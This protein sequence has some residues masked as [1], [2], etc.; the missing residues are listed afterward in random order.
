MKRAFGTEEYRN[1]YE[2]CK[3]KRPLE[4]SRNRWARNINMDFKETGL[5][6]MEWIHLAQNIDK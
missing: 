2:I 6:G 1:T 5:E 3:L 4:S